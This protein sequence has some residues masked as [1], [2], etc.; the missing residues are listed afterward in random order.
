MLTAL[1]VWRVIPGTIFLYYYVL[2]ELPWSFAVPGGYGDI[3]VGLTAIPASFLSRNFSRRNLPVLLVWQNL[4]LL[5]LTI[6]VRAALVNALHNPESMRPLTHFPLS[7]LPAMLV[8]L[9]LMIHVISIA[10]IISRLK[11][12]PCQLASHYKGESFDEHL[13]RDSSLAVKTRASYPLSQR[14]IWRWL[15]TV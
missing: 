6:V 4:A 8:P 12:A 13:F 2:R 1:H 11:P 5:D 10:Q 3:L 9:T 14:L 7:M 15:T